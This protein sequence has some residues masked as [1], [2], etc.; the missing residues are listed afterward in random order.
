MAEARE[1][2]SLDGV[3]TLYADSVAA[4]R[5]WL[6]AHGRTSGPIWLTVHH[7]DSSTPSVHFQEAI[8]HAVCFGWVDSK[9]VKRDGDSFLLKF[10][11]RTSRSSFGAKNQERAERMTREGLMTPAGQEAID[12]AKADGRW[13]AHSAANGR[14]VPADLREEFNRNPTAWQHFQAFP[15]S[16]KRLILQWISGAVRPETRA[17]RI[18]TTVDMAARNERANHPKRS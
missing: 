5:G 16:S 1:N 13:D 18:T 6:E 14:T 9:A 17:R 3:P 4:W 12:A 10:S 8:E 2:G 11:R 7:L 15:P